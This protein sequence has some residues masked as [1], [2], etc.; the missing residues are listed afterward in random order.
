MKRGFLWSF[1]WVL[2]C[3]LVGFWLRQPWLTARLFHTDEAVQAYKTVQLMQTGNYRY[4]PTEFHGPALPYFSSWLLNLTNSAP[5]KLTE[6][7]IRAVPL[8]FGL[9]TILS[10]LLWLPILG[11]YGTTI[12]A[13]LFALDPP[14]IFYNTYF[15]HESLLLLFCSTFCAAIL[16]GYKTKKPYWYFIAGVSLGLMHATK[17]TFVFNLAW[18]LIATAVWHLINQSLQVRQLKIKLWPSLVLIVVP[19]LIISALFYSSFLRNPSGIIDSLRGYTHWFARAAGSSPHIHPWYFYWERLLFWRVSGG[20]IFTELPIYILSVGTLLY[21]FFRPRLLRE[22]A[23]T[24]TVP[25]A[26]YSLGL[27]LTYT[28][29]PYKTP[30]CVLTFHFGFLLLAANTLGAILRSSP[31]WHRTAGLIVTAFCL[32][33]CL[34]QSRIMLYRAPSSPQNPWVYAHTDPQLKTLIDHVIGVVRKAPN[35]E[36]VIIKVIAPDADYWPL[37]WY[38][39]SIKK[40][41]W[42]SS[43]PQDLLADV[44]VVNARLR[45]KLEDRSDEDWIMAGFHKLR[46]NVYLVLYV[47]FDLWK[48]YIESRSA[49]KSNLT[50]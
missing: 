39:R 2:F 30:W 20:P 37:P 32:A 45:L 6:A 42:Y 28:A 38:F 27:A 47:K 16:N 25:L 10:L 33:A 5:E 12:A 35:P 19:A 7:H 13:I 40:V 8:I 46:P 43:I 44:F 26:V 9:L 1:A 48:R 36:Q 11:P 50:S 24:I 22:I 23:T 31:I 34:A 41:G 14:L 21:F 18:W 3:C 17:E 49:P 4:D 29:L 15:I